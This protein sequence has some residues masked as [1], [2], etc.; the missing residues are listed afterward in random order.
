ML[1]NHHNQHLT[2]ANIPPKVCMLRLLPESVSSPLSSACC[3]TGWAS[4]LLL[5]RRL[6][7]LIFGRPSSCLG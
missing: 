7:R 5:L 1:A 6:L 4:L 3:R 2:G